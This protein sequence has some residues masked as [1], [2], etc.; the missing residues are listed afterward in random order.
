[1]LT[2]S[3]VTLAAVV[4]GTA[5]TLAPVQALEMPDCGAL[6]EWSAKLN[7]D[8]TFA[9][10]PEVEVA[11]ILRDDLVVPLFG[12]PAIQW[13]NREILDVREALNEC[14]A[15]T[16]DE[17]TGR[18][19]Y[20]AIKAIG[21]SR[22]ALVRRQQTLARLE[23]TVERLETY[24]P[25]RRLAG[26]LALARDVLRGEPADLEAHGLEQMPNWLDEMEQARDHVTAAE[27]ESLAE[28][29][30]EREAELRA[31]FAEDDK[32]LAALQQEL[33][34]VPVSRAGLTRLRELE[35]SPVL[36]KAGPRQLDD[37]RAGVQRKRSQIQAEMRR[38][39]Q[40]RAQQARQERLRLQQAQAQRPA[41]RPGGR[42]AAGAAPR[43]G[44]PDLPEYLGEVI[45]GDE[46]EEAAV[47]D[48][49][50]GV[51]HREA[52]RQVTRE[53]GFKQTL[54]LSMTPGYGRDARMVE[55]TT[56]GDDVGQIDYTDY[57]ESAIEPDAVQQALAGRYGDPDAV[58]QVDGGRL[59]TWDDGDQILQVFAA[60]R[61][62]NA[63]RHKGYHSR[64][65]MA[66]WSEDYAEHLEAV[67]E[68]CAE[69]WDKPQGEVSLNDRRYL[70]QNCPL[71]P[72][73]E[74]TAGI[75]TVP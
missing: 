65:S 67:N 8:E 42:Q 32:A 11:N 75:N 27:V 48:L 6:E 12:A 57:F 70:G 73:A 60:N 13:S 24:R 53:Q 63:V 59:M 58:R 72:G 28:R 31:A 30:A 52:I 14:R 64:L 46:V 33:A 29:L 2:P 47:L 35:R 38:Q 4:L 17:A 15:A 36:R 7:P 1:M 66:L 40:E 3:R 69:I 39:E 34:E 16:Q 74:K 37:F 5:V 41:G 45:G 43:G 20:D 21:G 51:D 44:V 22:R 68:R 62:H 25:S 10:M 26:Q 54:T 56:M 49:R 55:F 18:Q 19:L 9:P 71:M 50:P 61:V 23:R